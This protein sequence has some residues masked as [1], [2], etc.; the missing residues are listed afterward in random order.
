MHITY[1][2]LLTHWT[3]QRVQWAGRGAASPPIGLSYPVQ[4]RPWAGFGHV[5]SGSSWTLARSNN[6]YKNGYFIWVTEYSA[7]SCVPLS[8]EVRYYTAYSVSRRLDL[9]LRV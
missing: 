9:D 6:R 3:V 1:T 5:H 2:P 4:T 7:R 8:R